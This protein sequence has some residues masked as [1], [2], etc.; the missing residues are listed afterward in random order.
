MFLRFASC[1]NSEVVFV[2]NV[3]SWHKWANFKGEYNE[4]LTSERMESLSRRFLPNHDWNLGDQE[5][6]AKLIQI[7]EQVFAA[8]VYVGP[9]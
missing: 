5:W 1:K 9:E 6:W 7:D 3:V 2:E 4:E 8:V